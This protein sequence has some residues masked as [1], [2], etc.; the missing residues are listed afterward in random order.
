MTNL[1]GTHPQPGGAAAHHRA[2][3]DEPL[4]ATTIH[5]L[6]SLPADVRPRALPTQFVRIANGLCRRWPKE[7]ACLAYFDDLLID[8][9]GGR[10]GF[11]IGIVLEI[12]SLKNYFETVVHRAPQTVWDEVAGRRRE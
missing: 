7:A 6:A 3:Q 8:R 5:W 12:A 1:A 11:P 9:R 4:E 10:R 2:A